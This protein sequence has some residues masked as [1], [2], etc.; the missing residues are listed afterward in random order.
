MRHGRK[1]VHLSR[2]TAHRNALLTNLGKSLMLHKRLITTLAKAKA[3]QPTIEPILTKA[4]EDTMETR[5]SVFSFFQDK[6]PTKILFDEIAHKIKERPG[7]YTRI[8]KLTPR[9]GDNASMALIE[10]V[11]YNTTFSKTS[12]KKTTRRSRRKKVVD[13]SSTPTKV[14][15]EEVEVK[16]TQRQVEAQVEKKL[17]PLPLLLLQP[18]LLSRRLSP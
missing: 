13:P 4:K 6:E 8:V 17:N 14:G 3:L 12:K 7:G 16:E 5:K 9:A 1:K 10:L 11:D 18:L 15:V 2:S